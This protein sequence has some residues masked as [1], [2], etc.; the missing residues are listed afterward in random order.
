M[1][2][3]EKSAVPIPLIKNKDEDSDALEGFLPL[4][5]DG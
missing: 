4:V 2:F 1:R 3:V 5:L